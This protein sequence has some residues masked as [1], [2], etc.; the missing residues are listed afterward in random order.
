MVGPVFEGACTHVSVQ[1][2][3]KDGALSAPAAL[4][5]PLTDDLLGIPFA[6]GPAVDVGS[7]KEIDAQF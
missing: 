5:K 2:G 3:G 4:G 1:L 6:L 7:V